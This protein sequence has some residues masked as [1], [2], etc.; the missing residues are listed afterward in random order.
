MFPPLDGATQTLPSRTYPLLQDTQVQVP[1]ADQFPESQVRVWVPAPLRMLQ[2]CA[3]GPPQVVTSHGVPFDWYPLSQETGTGGVTQEL[4]ESQDMAGPG[5]HAP[6]S[7]TCAGAQSLVDW[8]GT[9][10]A[11]FLPAQAAANASPSTMKVYLLMDIQRLLRVR[12]DDTQMN[13]VSFRA[14][15]SRG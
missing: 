9:G 3:P 13:E 7:Q 8:Q 6:C 5:L 1:H 2:A 10:S 4:L 15:P 12:P 14:P 11:A